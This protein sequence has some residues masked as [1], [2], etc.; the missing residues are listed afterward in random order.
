MAAEARG[1]AKIGRKRLRRVRLRPPLGGRPILRGRRGGRNLARN[2]SH[3]L[4]GRDRRPPGWPSAFAGERK[5]RRYYELVEIRWTGSPSAISSSKTAKCARCSVLCR[6]PG[7]RY[8]RGGLD[9]AHRRAV[10]RFWP[11]FLYARTLMVGCAAGEG[12]LDA[13]TNLAIPHRRIAR[14]LA[15]S[16]RARSEMR[17]VVVKEFRPGI[18]RR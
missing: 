8:R 1:I 2:R 13:P 4:A 3:R 5:D 12:H 14:G 17:D 6:R 18:A 9:P 16:D 15:E 11:R 7:S 10:R